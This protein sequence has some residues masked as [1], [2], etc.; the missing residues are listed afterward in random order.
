MAVV[1]IAAGLL[2]GFWNPQVC[3]DDKSVTITGPFEH[4][5]LFRGAT[6]SSTAFVGLDGKPQPVV[7]GFT[8]VG[9]VVRL[10]ENTWVF[11]RT[12]R[13]VET[14]GGSWPGFFYLAV[15]STARPGNKK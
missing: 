11:A 7:G 12:S 2:V 5:P 14:T 6:V 4:E 1:V 9:L 8:R 13:D 3:A 15:P 10:N